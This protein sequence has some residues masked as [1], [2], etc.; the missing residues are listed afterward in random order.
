M[1]F[2]N[3]RCLHCNQVLSQIGATSLS[4]TVKL[5][6]KEVHGI[7]S[8]RTAEELQ[9]APQYFVSGYAYTSPTGDGGMPTMEEFRWLRR[10][11]IIWEG[12]NRTPEELAIRYRPA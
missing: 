1:T 8:N 6:D 4:F 5:H 10:Q 11:F 9:T 3:W 7:S 2:H 12:D